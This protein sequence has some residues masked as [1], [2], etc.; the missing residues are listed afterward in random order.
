MPK[1]WLLFSWKKSNKHTEDRKETK[2][3]EN[4]E[5]VE[6]EEEPPASSAGLHLLRLYPSLLASTWPSSEGEA[7]EKPPPPCC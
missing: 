6:E 5:E 2:K 3:E 4:K 1:N 7:A